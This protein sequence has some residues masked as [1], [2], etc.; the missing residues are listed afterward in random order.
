M[1]QT[2]CVCLIAAVPYNLVI[3]DSTKVA[4][5]VTSTRCQLT[6]VD[7]HHK[8]LC[9]VTCHHLE[10]AQPEGSRFLHGSVY[11]MQIEKKTVITIVYDNI[12]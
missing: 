12:T 6:E 9:A 10:I 8:K 3:Q 5:S 2:D 11:W 1:S 7:R 4:F